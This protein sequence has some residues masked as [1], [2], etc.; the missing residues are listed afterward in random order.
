MLHTSEMYTS[1]EVQSAVKKALE[2]KNYTDHSDIK[3]GEWVYYR[4][5]VNHYW[6]GPIKVLAKDGKHLHCLKQGSAM[7][8]NTDDGLLHRPE[9]DLGAEEAEYIE[10]RSLEAQSVKKKALEAK[11]IMT[12]RPW[13]KV[14]GVK[15]RTQQTRLKTTL[16]KVFKKILKN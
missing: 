1:L 12:L 9:E 13:V 10:E 15:K 6:Q 3:V 4:T 11:Y 14:Y 2:A 7:D 5:N 16:L 8:V